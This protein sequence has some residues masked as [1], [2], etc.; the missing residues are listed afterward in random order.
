MYNN[1]YPLQPNNYP[2]NNQ[3][4]FQ[5]QMISQPQQMISQP[6][7]YGQNFKPMNNMG[8]QQPKPQFMQYPNQNFNPYIQQQIPPKN[9]F[10]QPMPQ[11]MNQQM[12]LPMGQQFPQ[13][14][15]KPFPQQQMN[16]SNTGFQQQNQQKQ[17]VPSNMQ[18]QGIPQYQQVQ[19]QPQ[20][21]QLEKNS[22]MKSEQINNYNQKCKNKL[23]L[24]EKVDKM[25]IYE[26]DLILKT[27]TMPLKIV[28]D[29]NFPA[30]SPKIY[31]RKKYYHNNI[32]TNTFEIEFKNGIYN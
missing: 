28:L 18:G 23:I 17:F 9:N 27:L 4:P 8:Y 12:P 13:Q 11:Q 21:I 10:Q 19:Q 6:Q 3:Q 31:C 7:G 16:Q 32:N 2:Y 1:N 15:M 25:D 29:E 14:N 26:A 30:T 22:Q 20:N 24:K 5:N